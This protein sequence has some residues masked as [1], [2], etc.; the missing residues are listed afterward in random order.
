MDGYALVQSKQSG[1]KSEEY[2]FQPYSS[3]SFV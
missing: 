2:L 3:V 1:E